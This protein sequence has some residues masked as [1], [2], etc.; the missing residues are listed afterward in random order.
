[1]CPNVALLEYEITLKSR[2]RSFSQVRRALACL[3]KIFIDYSIHEVSSLNTDS[4]LL[5]LDPVEEHGLSFFNSLIAASALRT[6]ETIVSDGKAF[7][8]VK[9]L[10]RIPI[11]GKKV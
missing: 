4:L 9:E 7:D 1:M 5:H 6:D 3:K 10:K 8:K 2:G 11:S